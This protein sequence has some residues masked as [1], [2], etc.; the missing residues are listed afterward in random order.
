ME[1]PS[2]SPGALEPA[3]SH[4]A[5]SF[6]FFVPSL[7]TEVVK[8][9]PEAE[10]TG[11]QLGGRCLEEAP[12]EPLYRSTPVP[13]RSCSP[14]RPG[15]QARPSGSALEKVVVVEE[16]VVEAT[17]NTPP[18][19]AS[20][21]PPAARSLEPPG[22]GAPSPGKGKAG[23]AEAAAIT[24]PALAPPPAGGEETDSDGE[25]GPKVTRSTRKQ[26]GEEKEAGG[27]EPAKEEQAWQDHIKKRKRS[28]GQEPYA[29]QVRH[30]GAEAD[31]S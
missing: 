8:L 10:E 20:P 13:S 5:T 21:P 3:T 9:A 23:K 6:D 18:A 28:L 16:V 4:S 19:L 30:Q 7:E 14:E 15:E 29:V 26:G 31:T 22:P 24:P 11:R 2:I 27:S 1:P 12:G 17:A 25:L